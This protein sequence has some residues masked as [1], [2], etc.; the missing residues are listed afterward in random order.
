MRPRSDRGSSCTDE[1]RSEETEDRAL[2]SAITSMKTIT[3]LATIVLRSQALVFVRESGFARLHCSCVVYSNKA[4]DDEPAM[5][6][7]AW[8]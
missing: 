6:S 1:D 2:I 5:V 8:I 4:S 7:C 3:I